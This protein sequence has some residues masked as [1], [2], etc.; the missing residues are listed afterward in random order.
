MAIGKWVILLASACTLQS[1]VANAEQLA[2]EGVYAARTDGA[3]G[4]SEIA[5]EPIRGREGYALENALADQLGSARIYGDPY[6]RLL[7]ASFGLEESA[8]GAAALE[9]YADSRVYDTSDGEIEHTRCIR[10]VKHEDGSKKC[11]ESVTD[12]FECRR[13][14]VEFRPEVALMAGEGTLYR[15]QDS[16]ANSERYCANS[17]YVPDAEAMLGPMIARFARAVRLD[18]APEQRFNRYRILESRKGLEGSDRKAFKRAIKLTKSDPI[19]ACIAFEDIL[20]RNPFQRSALYNVALCR[21]ADGQLVLAAQAY[22][23]LIL[24]SDKSRFRNGL[25]RVESRI[26]AREQLAALD[27]PRFALARKNGQ[28]LPVE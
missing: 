2:V 16:F 5:I 10:K 12:V 18:L 9:G 8:N 22:D 13:L 21:E 3:I 27:Q 26:R 6:F 17:S 23:Q 19:G 4:V 28:N 14:H 7:P 20:T 15:R 1:G 25:A 24:A 11:V